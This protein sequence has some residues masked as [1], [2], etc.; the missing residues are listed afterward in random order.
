MN[1]K[2]ILIV[3]I[4]ILVFGNGNINSSDFR[5]LEESIMYIIGEYK[6]ALERGDIDTIKKISNKEFEAKTN[7]FLIK[8][9]SGIA[10]GY[11]NL[12]SYEAHEE[13]DTIRCI[14]KS[15]FVQRKD[16]TIGSSTF[17]YHGP[18]LFVLEKREKGY[19][20]IDTDLYE[21]NKND[22][23]I[24]IVLMIGGTIIVIRR[25]IKKLKKL[26]KY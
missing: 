19:Y 23:W 4:I 9:I 2:K 14:F 16:H 5:N 6:N 22:T 11:L 8:K 15:R 20:L 17:T 21:K 25:F 7:E 12:E 26:N 3:F 13:V 24:Y 10:F 18:I 1:I